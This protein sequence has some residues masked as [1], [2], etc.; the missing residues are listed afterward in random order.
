MRVKNPSRISVGGSGEQSREV[1]QVTAELGPAAGRRPRSRSPARRGW[2]SRRR[3][4]RPGAVDRRLEIARILA[5]CAISSTHRAPRATARIDVVNT[6]TRSPSSTALASFDA[7]WSPRIVT[8]VNDYDVRVAKVAGEHHLARPRR[9]RRVLPRPRRRLH[10]ALRETS[11]RAHRP[12]PQGLGLHRPAG[13]GAQA[14]RAGGAAILLF[15][16][17][18]TSTVGDRHDEIPDYVHT[19]AGRDLTDA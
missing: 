10:I 14:V 5:P 16:P 6:E 18:G 9:H 4:R 3:S 19:T 7:L 17:T 1:V 11:R 2:S 8:R 15:E 12:T 13:R